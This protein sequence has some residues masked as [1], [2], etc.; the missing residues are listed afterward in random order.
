MIAV[1]LGTTLTVN[2]NIGVLVCLRKYQNFLNELK[3]ALWVLWVL[4]FDCVSQFISA[5]GAVTSPPCG[6]PVH[7]ALAC[8][9]MSLS[10]TEE[11]D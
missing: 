11:S 2:I 7:R 9:F 1:S 3:R 10:V 6:Y 4:T 8:G 5:T